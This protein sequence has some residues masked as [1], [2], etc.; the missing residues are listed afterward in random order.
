MKKNILIKM[1]G[2][3]NQQNARNKNKSEE[4]VIDII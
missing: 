4:N 3:R 1:Q 2:T